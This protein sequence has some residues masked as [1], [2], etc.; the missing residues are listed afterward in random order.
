MRETWEISVEASRNTTDLDHLVRLLSF[1][2]GREA[3]SMDVDPFDSLLNLE[4]DFYNEGY[5]L[6]VADGARAGYL[7][8]RAFGIE[9]GFEKF[10]AMAR[11]YGR[12]SVW[13]SRMAHT[14]TRGD[15]DVESTLSPL[16]NNP[17][18]EKHIQTLLALVD[19]SS[20]SMENEE[21][22]VS[23]FDDRLNRAKA[24][25]KLIEKLIGEIGYED[26]PTGGPSHAS[27]V[28]IAQSDDTGKE[29]SNGDGNIESIDTKHIRQS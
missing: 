12:A 5:Q 10:R 19:P 21:D 2:T 11:I 23:Q 15:T 25:V 27:N 7:E 24:K 18:L 3:S 28:R 4:E 29:K 1:L 22:A 20:L 26:S 14:P 17:R 9:K 13:A 16:P 6:G 8:G